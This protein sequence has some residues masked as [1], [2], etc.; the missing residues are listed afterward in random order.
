MYTQSQQYPA[1]NQQRMFFNFYSKKF[2]NFSLLV[3]KKI[4]YTMISN[5]FD[6]FTLLK[7]HSAAYVVLYSLILVYLP[8]RLEAATFTLTFQQLQYKSCHITLFDSLFIFFLHLLYK[9]LYSVVS[10]FVCAWWTLCSYAVRSFDICVLTLLD[11]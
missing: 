6:T 8:K 7:Q 9:H 11:V 4:H 3:K 2:L 10:F 5:D 1:A